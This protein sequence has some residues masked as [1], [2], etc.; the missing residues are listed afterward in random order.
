MLAQTA[1]NIKSAQNLLEFGGFGISNI[2]ISILMSK[3][4]LPKLIPKLKVPTIYENT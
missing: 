3:M 2:P 4:I 1:P